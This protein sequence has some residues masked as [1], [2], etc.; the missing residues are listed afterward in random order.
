M[1]WNRKPR[2]KPTITWSI[3][4][5]QKGKNMQW[6]KKFQQIV[7]EKLEIYIQKNETGPLSCAMHKSRLNTD[8]RYKC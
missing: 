6:K 3:N 2:N 7:L 8:E 5:Q 1:E 4:L